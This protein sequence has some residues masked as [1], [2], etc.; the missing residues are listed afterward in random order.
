MQHFIHRYYVPNSYENYNHLV[1]SGNEAAAIDPFDWALAESEAGKL[2]VRLS[3]IWLTHG[4]PDHIKGVPDHFDGPVR[5]HPDI[6]G[7]SVTHPVPDDSTFRLGDNEI[8][9]IFTPGHTM[10]HLCFYCPAIPA[11]IAGD[12]LFNAGVG[13]TRSGDTD[14]LYESIR[15]L[16][17][18]PGN[19]R[20][21]NGH[22]YMPTNLAFSESIVGPVSALQMWR[23]RTE[24]TEK[25]TRPITTLDDEKEINLFLQQRDPVLAGALGLPEDAGDLTVF[26]A[27]RRR[28]DQW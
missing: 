25:N 17:T 14:A 16:M 9:V 24:K 13:N 23:A 10:D 5:G 8:E 26:R 2:G 15:K 7:V 12:T 11:L 3:E 18:L 20:L 21:Y 19:T 27:L 28:R 6:A 22:D 1:I 4:H